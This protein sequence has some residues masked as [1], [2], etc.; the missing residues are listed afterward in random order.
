MPVVAA[1]SQAAKS[2][3]LATAAR[4]ARLCSGDQTRSF[5]RATAGR[6]Y[7]WRL[8]TILGGVTVPALVTLNLNGPVR[9]P[10][11]WATFAVSLLVAISAAVEGFFRYGERWRHYRRTAELL[12]TEGWQFLQLTGHYR[13]HAAHALAYP[14][15]ASRVE[16]ILQ[17]DVDAYITTVA[18]EAAD[19][20]PADPQDQGQPPPDA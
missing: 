12:K 7:C 2:R 19:R 1:S 16:D 5:G 4:N 17:Q 15:F 3:S 18:A 13:R 11:S 10:L 6:Y 8:L 9:A 20:Q 14:L